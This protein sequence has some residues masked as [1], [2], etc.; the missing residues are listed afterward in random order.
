MYNWTTAPSGRGRS[1]PA[2][3][4]IVPS[5]D[6]ARV[7]SAQSLPRFYW[8]LL[9]LSVRNHGKRVSMVLTL[10]ALAALFLALV[11]RDAAR[12]MTNW[13]GFS[14]LWGV[15][16]VVAVLVWGGLQTNWDTYRRVREER[17]SLRREVNAMRAG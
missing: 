17:D 5:A 7:Y 12:D 6:E 10:L 13:I 8:A 4:L 11:D 2:V 15:I 1:L 3:P 9:I 16:P 14:P